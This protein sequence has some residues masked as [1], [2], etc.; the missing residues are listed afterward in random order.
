MLLTTASD[1]YRA[2]IDGRV[3]GVWPAVQRGGLW[4]ASVPYGWIVRLRNHLY[5]AGW[6]RIQRAPVPVV[7]VGNLS[8]GGTGKTPCVE[9][10]AG[11]YRDLGRRVAI[12]SRGY[13]RSG[14]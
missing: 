12:L 10:L 3:P 9:Y 13:G 2:L 8:L 11:F 6:K 5:D 1:Y 14:G 4:A 7:S